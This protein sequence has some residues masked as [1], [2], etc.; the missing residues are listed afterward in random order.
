MP[1]QVS[2]LLESLVTKYQPTW[3]MTVKHHPFSIRAL[4]AESQV[5]NYLT[6]ARVCM[7]NKELKPSLVKALETP[8]VGTA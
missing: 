5:W 3:S 1:I 6:R 4:N 7:N 8:A 2:G